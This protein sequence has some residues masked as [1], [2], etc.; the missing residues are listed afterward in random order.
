MM[1]YELTYGGYTVGYFPPRGRSGPPGRVPAQRAIYGPGM[2]QR[3][4]IFDIRPLDE[5]TLLFHQQIK[6]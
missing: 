3:W 1:V 5:Q 2:G 6:F 4:R